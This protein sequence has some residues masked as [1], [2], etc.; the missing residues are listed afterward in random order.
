M[1]ELT[2]EAFQDLTDELE[3]SKKLRKDLA[4]RNEELVRR[5]GLMCEQTDQIE[6]L[7][8]MQARNF[9]EIARGEQ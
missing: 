4:E 5:L 1:D 6:A 3:K 8:K 2:K 7:A 9:A